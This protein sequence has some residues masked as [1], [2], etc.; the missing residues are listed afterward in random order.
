MSKNRFDFW[1]PFRMTKERWDVFRIK[2]KGHYL[3]DIGVFKMGFIFSGLYLVLKYWISIDFEYVKFEWDILFSEYLI[4]LPVFMVGGWILAWY[5]WEHYE[6][7]F[8]FS[9]NRN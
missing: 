9:K 4:F 3:K 2:G 7:K 8:G 1:K 5:S 6:D